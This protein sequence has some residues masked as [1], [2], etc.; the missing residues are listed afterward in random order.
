[1]VI[2]ANECRKPSMEKKR[3]EP[4][5]YKK[6]YFE[7]LKQKERAFITQENDWA[8]DGADADE[9]MEYVN[10]ALIAKSDDVE[11]SSSSN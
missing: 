4:I 1:M 6:K 3:F 7:L 5:D 2:I 10:L 9:D 11:V 8:A